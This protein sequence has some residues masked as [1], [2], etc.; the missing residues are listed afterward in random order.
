MTRQ[1]AIALVLITVSVVLATATISN[2]NLQDLKTGYL[3]GATP[4]RQQVALVVGCVAGGLVIPPILNL[5]HTAYGF[6]GALPRAGMDPLQ[7]LAAP[8][9]TLMA[10]IATGILGAR[11]N[12]VMSASAPLSA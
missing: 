6:P 8:Q 9:A 2:D 7:V 11:W 4:W 5:L 1:A 12:G 10:K 3:L